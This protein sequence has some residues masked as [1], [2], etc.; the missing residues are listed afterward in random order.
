MY[1]FIV[2]NILV[3]F[4]VIA[5]V[6]FPLYFTRIQAIFVSIY[7]TYMGQLFESLYE[8]SKPEV[9]KAYEL[10]LRIAGLIVGWFL[11][12]FFVELLIRCV[13]YLCLVV[14]RIVLSRNNVSTG[15]MRKSDVIVDSTAPTEEIPLQQRQHLTVNDNK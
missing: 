13:T 15:N 2:E 11:L 1:F 14:V 10:G 8:L 3:Y 9:V 4:F 7:N 6:G 12:L 5:G